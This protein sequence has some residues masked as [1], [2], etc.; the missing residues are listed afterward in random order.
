LTTII[1]GR[2]TEI[3]EFC[4][5]FVTRVSTQLICFFLYI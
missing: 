4:Y 5:W 3:F 1:L 2:A